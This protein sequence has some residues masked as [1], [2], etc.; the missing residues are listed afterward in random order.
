MEKQDGKRRVVVYRR[1]SLK[2]GFQQMAQGGVQRFFAKVV[3]Q[4]QCNRVASPLHR[5]D[6]VQAAIKPYLPAV[7]LNLLQ[8]FAVQDDP[9]QGGLGLMQSGMGVLPGFKT[10][11]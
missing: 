10:R 6:V 4:Q 3:K 1:P 9:V 8:R 5:V 11:G 7:N 2:R